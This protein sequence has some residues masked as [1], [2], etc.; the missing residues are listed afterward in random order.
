M[1]FFGFVFLK[2][3]KIFSQLWI[4]SSAVKILIVCTSAKVAFV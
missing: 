4:F 1:V 2:K 3:P